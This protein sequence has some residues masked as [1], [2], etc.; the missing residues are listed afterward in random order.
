MKR[1]GIEILKDWVL[2]ASMAILLGV[3]LLGLF[4]M[5]TE[6]SEPQEKKKIKYVP[7]AQ[8]L[9]TKET[10]FIGYMDSTSRLY[11]LDSIEYGE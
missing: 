3:V 8:I 9:I 7:G 4:V 2:A 1:N 10:R 11:V 5:F 6:S